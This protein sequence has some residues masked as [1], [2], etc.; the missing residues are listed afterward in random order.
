MVEKEGL[1]VIDG[2]KS[3]EEQQ[4]LM[5]QKVLEVLPRLMNKSASISV[6]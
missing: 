5:R 3:I 2:T 6:S 1:T 4:E